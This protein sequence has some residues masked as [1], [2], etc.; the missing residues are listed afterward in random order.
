MLTQMFWLSMARR[1]PPSSSCSTRPHKIVPLH[2]LLPASTHGTTPASPCSPSLWPT[3]ASLQLSKGMSAAP[4]VGLRTREECVPVLRPPH[5]PAQPPLSPPFSP[6]PDRSQRSLHTDSRVCS[7]LLLQP[8]S[9]GQEEGWRPK[10]WAQWASIPRLPPCTKYHTHPFP[11]LS[12]PRE[13]RKWIHTRRMRA[14]LYR[15]SYAPFH[16]EECRR[17]RRSGRAQ[18]PL[19]SVR[20]AVPRPPC[21]RGS[22]DASASGART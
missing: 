10:G 17:K 2:S 14:M 8:T 19:G 4:V 9:T 22:S 3:T 7:R 12:C 18:G 15:L 16:I 13:R 5:S 1:S 11:S 6:C 20:C 21:E